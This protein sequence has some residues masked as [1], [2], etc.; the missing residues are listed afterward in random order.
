M[1]TDV[2]LQITKLKKNNTIT[3]QEYFYTNKKI[4]TK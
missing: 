4:D 2:V 1:M 3:I